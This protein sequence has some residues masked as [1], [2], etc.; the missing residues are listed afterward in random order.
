MNGT[1]MTIADSAR[2][3]LAADRSLERLGITVEQG[4]DGRAVASLIVVPEMANGHG[5]AHGGFVFAVA[6]TAFAVA[7]NTLGPDIATADAAIT[8]VT[9]ALIGERLI[10]TAEVTFN[11]GRRVIV[12]VAVRA[13]D[14]TVAI[15]R[16]T[17]RALRPS[18][19]S[20]PGFV[21]GNV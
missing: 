19:E 1:P 21:D 8:Y 12:D 18:G 17:G 7:A 16:G 9:P 10:A 6:D 2:S 4:A 3:L 20:R 15:Y 11:E 5:I 13:G 14:R